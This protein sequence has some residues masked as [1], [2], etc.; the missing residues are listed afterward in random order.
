M[1]KETLERIIKKAVEGEGYE[2]VDLQFFQSKGRWILRVYVDSPS[3]ITLEDCV[4][5]TKILDPLLDVEDIIPHSYNLEV[6]SPGLDRPLKKPEDFKRFAGKKALIIL[7]EKFQGRKKLKGEIVLVKEE[8][9]VIKENE[10]CIEVDFNMIKKA[11]LVPE[12]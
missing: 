10:D 8:G 6:S 2:F 4:K 5:V 1:V 7:K 9:V 12:F 3:G 11:H